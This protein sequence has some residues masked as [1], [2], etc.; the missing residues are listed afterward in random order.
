M[1][2]HKKIIFNSFAMP[3][4]GTIIRTV[5]VLVAIINQLLQLTGKSTLPFT[6]E[7]ISLTLSTIFT[8]ITALI[9]WWKNNNFT[10]ASQHAQTVLDALKAEQTHDKDTSEQTAALRDIEQPHPLDDPTNYTNPLIDTS[11]HAE[12]ERDQ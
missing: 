2:E 7:Q 1:A 3:D 12:S 11:N 5:L 9:A 8:T 6:D 10:H 4:T